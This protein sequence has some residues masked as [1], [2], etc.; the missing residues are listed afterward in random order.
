MVEVGLALAQ[1]APEGTEDPRIENLG[2]LE[3]AELLALVVQIGETGH[4]GNA[5]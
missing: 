3:R 4:L 2:L 1:E 5:R